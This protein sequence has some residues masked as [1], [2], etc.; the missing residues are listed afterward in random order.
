MAGLRDL[1]TGPQGIKGLTSRL[2]RGSALQTGS[3]FSQRSFEYVAASATGLRHKGKM[4]AASATAVSAALQE[5][6][7]MPLSITETTRAGINTDLT[8]MFGRGQ[9]AIKLSVS[10]AAEFFRQ[11]AELLASGVAM[12]YVLEA[13]GQE[14]S[15]KVRK[16][17]DGLSESL[18]AGVP[19]SEAMVSFPDAFDNVTRA[20]IASG[21]ASGTL[22]RTMSRLAASMEKR[23]ELRLKIKG[24]TSYPKIVAGVIGLIVVGIIKFMVPMYENIYASFNSELPVPTQVLVTLSENLLPVKVTVS[25]PT[26]FFLADNIESGLFGLLGRVAFLVGFIVVTESMRNKAGKD[27]KIRNTIIKWAFL[28]AVTIFGGNYVI[29]GQSLIGWGAL[30]AVV[31]G[32]KT[33]INSGNSNA[34]N[35][36][37]ADRVRFRLPVIGNITRL[38]ATFQWATTMS[39]ALSA[40][41]PLGRA[42]VLAGATSGSRWHASLAEPLQNAVLGGRPLSE[43]LADHTD[44]FTPSIRAMVATGE[45]T[46]ELSTMFDNIARTAESEVDSQIAGLAAKVEV[47]LLVVMGVVVGGLLVAL[48]LPII[49]LATAASGGGGG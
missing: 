3:S 43:A 35:A 45:V 41:V 47:L 10:E 13:I 16:I 37:I 20:Y 1:L 24:V 23:N 11:A 49:N 22:P 9:K 36:R 38:N 25:F 48:Y 31:F 17:C 40:G 32:I 15:S 2:G 6:G 44:L 28:S 26:P 42:L 19:L 34:R 8:D 14:A 4:Q 18:A 29:V 39:G 7:W 27:A 30:F 12:T 21:E 33:F 5:D 46:G